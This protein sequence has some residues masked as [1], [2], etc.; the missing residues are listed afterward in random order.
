M[1]YHQGFHRGSFA[2][3]ALTGEA[4]AER[5]LKLLEEEV[6]R[7]A[8]NGV[9]EAEFRAARE[10]AAFEADTLLESRKALL[11]GAVLDLYYGQPSE[12]TVARG[13]HLRAMTRKEFNAL[14]RE[15]FADAPEHS[16]SVVAH[17]GAANEKQG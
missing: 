13:D 4:G 5:A 1:T 16:V 15:V 3:Y 14:L 12:L 17:G 9:D 2:F 6:A 10:A 11:D 7:L 8:E